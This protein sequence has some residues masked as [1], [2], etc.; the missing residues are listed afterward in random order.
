METRRLAVTGLKC[1]TDYEERAFQTKASITSQFQRSKANDLMK[2][3]LRLVL[4]TCEIKSYILK[5]FQVKSTLLEGS[6][7]PLLPSN[8][9]ACYEY[10]L[11]Q[12][13]YVYVF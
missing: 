5:Q 11:F 2:T 9:G 10:Q 1:T 3:G 4:E 7:P 13:A 12:H 6:R 8:P